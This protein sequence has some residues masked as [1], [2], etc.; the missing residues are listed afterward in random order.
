[1]HHAAKAGVKLMILLPQQVNAGIAGIATT[2]SSEDTVSVQ[3]NGR[4][5][6]VFPL[7]YVSVFWPDDLHNEGHQKGQPREP[8]WLL[9]F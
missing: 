6:V 5:N 4:K 8:V 9:S 2:P 3:W 1:M 7:H